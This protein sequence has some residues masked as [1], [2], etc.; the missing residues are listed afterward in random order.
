MW[1]YLRIYFSTVKIHL[2][3]Y[4][5]KFPVQKAYAHLTTSNARGEREVFTYCFDYG[6]EGKY[7]F[8]LMNVC[9]IQNARV[10]T[11]RLEQGLVGAKTMERG[12]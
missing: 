3:F 10:K 1:Q 2:K 9:E 6:F 7:S 5:F 11:K 4:T 12:V 8:S